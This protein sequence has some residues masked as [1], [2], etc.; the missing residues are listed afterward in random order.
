MFANSVTQLKVLLQIPDDKQDG[1]WTAL[2]TFVIMSMIFQVILALLLIQLRNLSPEE[3]VNPDRKLGSQ[4]CVQTR[5]TLQRINL[6]GMIVTF[7]I[8]VFNVLIMGLGINYS[9]GFDGGSTTGVNATTGA[10]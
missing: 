10:Q 7:F 1:T 3:D 5:W 6:I 2:F 8:L 4:C 9:G